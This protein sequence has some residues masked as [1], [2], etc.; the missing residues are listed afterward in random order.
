[1]KERGGGRSKKK[2][3]ANQVSRETPLD[4]GLQAKPLA[5]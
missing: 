4:Q 5:P 3:T 1:M 2:N